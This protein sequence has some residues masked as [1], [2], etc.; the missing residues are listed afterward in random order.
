ME[1][2]GVSREG[3]QNQ[4]KTMAVLVKLSDAFLS[5]F[6]LI[7]SLIRLLKKH[8]QLMGI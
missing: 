4:T 6:F 8:Q 2:S 1:F 3:D 5:Y 7:I